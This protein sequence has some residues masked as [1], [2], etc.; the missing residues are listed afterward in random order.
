MQ[1]RKFIILLQ[2]IDTSTFNQFLKYVSSPYFNSN[3]RAITLMEVLKKYHPDYHSSALK[4]E[5]VYKKVF[6]NKP[7][8]E[9]A[10]KNL[11][12]ELTRLFENFLTQLKFD[13]DTTYQEEAF[14]ASTIQLNIFDLFDRKVN[15]I[16]EQQAFTPRKGIEYYHH[17]FRLIELD[18]SKQ[19][20]QK[21]RLKD[22]KLVPMLYNLDQ[23]YIANKLRYYCVLWNRQKMVNEDFP[24][25]QLEPILNYLQQNSFTDTPIIAFW[26]KLFLFFTEEQNPSHYNE[27]KTLLADQGKYIPIKDVRD[28]F[29]SLVNYCARKTRQ[30]NHSYW[31]ELLENY[32]QMLKQD[33]LLEGGFFSSNTHFI[34][35]PAIAL[36]LG[37]IEWVEKF[38]NDYQ[39]KVRPQER[40]SL[41]SYVSALVAYHKKAYWDTVLLL[42]DFEIQGVPSQYITSKFLLVKAYF[43]LEEFELMEAV[44]NATSIYIR[45]S[46]KISAS[47]KKAYQNFILIVTKMA[48]I[49]Q[50][51][52]HLRDKIPFQEQKKALLEE[53]NTIGLLTQKEWIL[54]KLKVEE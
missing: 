28:A 33:L 54:Q 17:Q 25:D 6:G 51:Y 9:Q 14:Y 22:T 29:I 48:R 45:R 32:E 40:K 36:R 13:E 10:I 12:T 41:V 4:L 11:L 26:Y 49:W 35:I 46:E 47:P 1:N 43:E 23:Y 16:I 19:I 31:Q 7:F 37:R 5:R 39:D 38:I 2:R 15:Q 21:I 20:K 24:K 18:Y 30:G 27:L 52:G 8:R 42:Q 53:M 34:N 44:V 3:K 50:N